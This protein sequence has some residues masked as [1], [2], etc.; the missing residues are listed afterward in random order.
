MKKLIPPYLFLIC[1]ASTVVL[2]FL[3]PDPRAISIPLNFCGIFIM[4][5]GVYLLAKARMFIEKYDTEIH[6]FKQPRNMII[7]GPFRYSRNP[8]YGGFTLMIMG[9]WFIFGNW[10][11]AMGWI[12]FFLCCNFWYIP[13]EEKNFE[14]QFG[15]VYLDYKSKVRR[16]V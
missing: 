1:I 7:E 10:Y 12:L 4:L 15:Q 5:G 13:F 11:G 16:W 9:V 8:I 6:T 3:F 14:K 2:F